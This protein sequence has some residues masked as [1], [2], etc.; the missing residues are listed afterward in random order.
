MAQTEQPAP[1]PAGPPA[2]AAPPQAPRPQVPPPADPPPGYAQPYPPAPYPAPGY[3]PPYPPPAYP[4]PYGYP[5]PYPVPVPVA[6]PPPEP[7]SVIYDWDPDAPAPKGYQMVDSVNGRT[8][9]IGIALLGS[10]WFVSI[11]AASVGAASEEDE[12]VDEADGVTAGD[13]TVLYVPIV[14][15]LIAIDTL[16]AKTSGVGAL[17]ADTV[18]QVGG[19]AGS[20]AGIVDRRYRLVR[21]D[22]G[23]LTVTPLFW[24]GGRG[25]AAGGRF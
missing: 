11:I 8:L 2:Q 3:P 20:V 7:P 19:A 22:Y 1:P 4:P 5:Q 18:L 12:A 13:W 24:P 25:L 6:P 14:G 21:N 10:G 17:I 9:G 15:P 23:S 16:D